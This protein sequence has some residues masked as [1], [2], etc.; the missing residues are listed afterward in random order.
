[1]ITPHVCR[2]IKVALKGTVHG[3][4]RKKEG[5]VCLERFSFLFT[6][7]AAIDFMRKAEKKVLPLMARPL[8]GWGRGVKGRA[9][10]E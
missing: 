3:F 9:I 4:S 1:M 8:R 10:K 5:N 6:R 7:L 2:N